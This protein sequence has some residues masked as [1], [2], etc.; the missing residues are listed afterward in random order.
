MD[1][2]RSIILIRSDDD[3]HDTS[4]S[5]RP[6]FSINNESIISCG[7]LDNGNTNELI[8][9]NVTYDRNVHLLH[10]QTPSIKDLSKVMEEVKLTTRVTPHRDQG[11]FVNLADLFP[12]NAENGILNEND[13]Y[14]NNL[15]LATFSVFMF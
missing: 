8:D 5:V 12:I 9:S 13:F 14:G 10:F 15:R 7:S 4:K 3:L 1:F 11:H 6:A 2:S